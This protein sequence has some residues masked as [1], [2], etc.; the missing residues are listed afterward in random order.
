MVNITSKLTAIFSK[1][2][3][4]SRNKNEG[5]LSY[6][7]V[8]E[9]KQNIN[10]NDLHADLTSSNI[11]NKIDQNIY[12]DSSYNHHNLNN[13]LNAD[14]TDFSTIPI[15]PPNN[16]NNGNNDN[17]NLPLIIALSSSFGAI[18]IAFII[19]IIYFIWLY[20][21]SSFNFNN[22]DGSSSSND[23]ST[24]SFVIP[25]EYDDEENISQQENLYLSEL[26][27]VDLNYY[28]SS[29]IFQ[30]FNPP[31]IVSYNSSL[32]DNE[33]RSIIDRGLEAFYFENS[34][35]NDL[36][37]LFNN[38]SSNQN[39][40]S[41]S[42]LNNTNSN[43]PSNNDINFIVHD[44]TE[45]TFLND[46]PSCVQLNLPLPVKERGEHGVLYFETKIFKLKKNS[47]ISIGLITKPYPNFR[48]PG[49]NKFSV[50]YESSGI[51]RINQPF[52][53]APNILPP[54]EEGDVVGIG[55]KPRLGTVFFTRNGKKLFEIIHNMRITLYPAIGSYNGTGNQ[56]NVNL[57]KYG[58]VFI[59]ANVKRWWFAPPNGVIGA[60]PA[61]GD[62]NLKYVVVERGEILPPEYPYDEETFFGPKALLLQNRKK[63]K[64]I[65]PNEFKNCKLL[66]K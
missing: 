2:D 30:K 65:K 42:N 54:L 9:N 44:K 22:S 29:K 50:A 32:T 7:Q 48:L 25:N 12:H 64:I 49:Y 39:Q 15:Q 66:I 40:I 11:A 14:Y 47:V 56:V 62:D 46:T 38:T 59:E 1:N 5:T 21:N 17:L 35:T 19:L 3:G 18:L 23:Y 57:G 63:A 52:N 13:N 27:D 4:Q 61:Y 34:T 60:P 41:N 43:S 28:N 53:N 55:F 20:I 51:A 45:I 36:D 58:F 24:T 33:Y 26:S 16:G 31:T 10:P 8:M 37:D 6:F